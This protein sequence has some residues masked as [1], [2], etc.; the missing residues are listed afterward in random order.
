MIAPMRILGWSIRSIAAQLG[1]A[2]STI[3]RELRRN[4]DESGAYAGYW[5]HRD[6][7]RRRCTIR[8]S[9]LRSGGLATYVQE[10][11]QCR[12]SPE[13]IAHRVRLD[14]PHA[15]QMRISHQT[16]STWLAVDHR[17]GG[18]WSRYLRHHRRRRK[19]YGS[20][21]RAAHIPGRV[22]LADRPTIVHRR[23]RLGDWEGD[24][25]VGQGQRGFVATHVDRRSRFLLATKVS[26]RTA[27]EVTV[28]TR[29]LLQPLPQQ[30]RR[31]LTVENGSEWTA[32]R[33]LQRTL[34]LQVYCAAPYAA[35]ERGTN[36]NTNG[37]LR[38][39][40]PKQT[41]FSMVTAHQLASVVKELNH[42]P[43]KC[44]AYRTPAEVFARATS[45]ARRI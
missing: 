9:C 15:T 25:L 40:F 12:W 17:T 26:R 28:A 2:P 43:R 14:S 36:E 29:K 39:Y 23:G 4:C 11:L 8:R 6:A 24:L 38:D 3:S 20:G 18:S 16:I 1:R 42:R 45:V 5:A 32:F 35:W 44:L 37:L 22:S 41:D 33:S 7:Q 34:G 19:R 10:K 13:Q 27:A 30:M 31:T 21:P